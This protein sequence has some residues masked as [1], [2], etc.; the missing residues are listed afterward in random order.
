L[1]DSARTTLRIRSAW[2]EGTP[3]NLVLAQNFA[4]DTAGRQLLKT[5]TLHFNTKRLGD[6]GRLTVRIRG[7]DTARRP[8][9]QFIQG[10]QVV[11]AGPLRNGIFTARLFNPGEYELRVLYDT[12]GN[13]QWDPGLFFGTRRQPEVVVPVTQNINVKADFDNEFERSL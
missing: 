11:F 3:Y 12:N 1:L 13:N 4:E 9:L 8:V 7:I 10:S 2:R 6:Y 5:D